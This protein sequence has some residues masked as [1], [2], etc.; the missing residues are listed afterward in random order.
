MKNYHIAQEY[1]TKIS[2]LDHAITYLQWDQLVMMPPGGNE[3]R[4]AAI[5]ELTAMRHDLLCAEELSIAV[6]NATHQDNDSM[7]TRSLQEMQVQIHNATC[8]P[9][10]LVKAQSLAGSKCEHG[11]RQQR[12]DNDWQAFLI[13]FQEVVKLARE[14]AQARY[15]AATK[16]LATPYDALLNLYCS[17]DSSEHI[18][19]VFSI[20]TAKIPGIIEQ[21]LDKQTVELTKMNGPYPINAQRHLNM[22]LM[23]KLRFDFQ[24]G[25]LD[26]S[27]HPFS[28][29]SRGDHRI[30]TRFREN[31]FFEALLAT[32]HETGHA[33]YEAGL[34]EK[35]DLLPIGSARNMCI[36]ESQS[37]LFEKHILLTKPFFT[38]FANTI[39]EILPQTKIFR[40]EQMRAVCCRVEPSFIRVEADEVTY[41][42]H[43]ALRFEIEK[44][45]INCKIEAVEIP[46]I[47]D[48]KM[49]RYL[50]LSTAGNYRNGCLQDIHWTDGSFGYFPSYTMGALN[51]A[52]LFAAIIR[53]HPDWQ[54]HMV[55][56]NISFICTWL[57]ENIW[58]IASSMDSQE[59]MKRATGEKTSAKAFLNHLERRYLT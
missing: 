33:S 28:T 19:E 8:L 30:T 42:L 45:L 6:E 12:L 57:E 9:A 50:G 49:Q 59:I 13:N 20:L 39:H 24:R 56:G 21:A 44:E 1:F 14:E 41:P 23:E 53:N 29:G 5:A 38:F 32:A 40:A 51:A 43:V 52:Q 54:E 47:W 3:G 18:G 15:A 37:L 46:E 26:I 25:R 11:W 55:K 27:S 17:G 31:E 22:A 4:A 10:S 34:P 16:P 35:W 7:T 36:H 2:R 48:E 58:S